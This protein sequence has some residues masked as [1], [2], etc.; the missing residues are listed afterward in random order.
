MS[1]LSEASASFLGGF[2]AVISLRLP[3]EIQFY[4]YL[5]VIP[6]VFSLREP[7]QHKHDNKE[8]IWKGI[9][10]IV[11]YSLH[12]HREVKWLILFS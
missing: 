11:R 9:V 10:K 1:S 2:L 6:L 12:E 8:G 3:L 5:A 4:L 7:Q